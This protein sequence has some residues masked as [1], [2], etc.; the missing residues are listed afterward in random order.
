MLITFFLSSSYSH[1]LPL[2]QSL[3]FDIIPPSV[4]PSSLRPS[5]LP[6]PLYFHFQRSPFYVL[7]TQDISASV[8]NRTI[9]GRFSNYFFPSETWKTSS[10]LGIFFNCLSPKYACPIY[11]YLCLIC[12]E[13]KGMKKTKTDVAT[14]MFYVISHDISC[15]LPGTSTLYKNIYKLRQH[16]V[17]K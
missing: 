7:I 3:L 11:K 8:L 10:Q 5:F 13:S 4:Q 14:N 1:S 9:L 6:S 12:D 16:T 17:I 15:R 2:R